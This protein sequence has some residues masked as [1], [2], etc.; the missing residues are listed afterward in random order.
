MSGRLTPG[1]MRAQ[2]LRQ[3]AL[4]AGFGPRVAPLGSQLVK[5]A[6]VPQR[7][8]V[9]GLPLVKT[10]GEAK[11]PPPPPRPALTDEDR[12]KI[13]ARTAKNA[14]I[15]VLLAEVFP[16]AFCRPRV[17]LA[18]G[19]Y[20]RILDVVSDNID[21]ADLRAFLKY[22]CRR[23]DYLAAMAHGEPRRNLDGSPADVPTETQQRDAA[24]RVYGKDRAPAVL[25][26]I[27]TRAKTILDLAKEDMRDAAQEPA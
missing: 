16:A 4:K 1:E 2:L 11:P 25:A 24:N 13:A 6:E 26:K 19:T 9:D 7:Q 23:R 12:A 14:E 10:K 20:E 15:E 18:I 3:T 5:H 21:P 22:W 27:E 8:R 17:P